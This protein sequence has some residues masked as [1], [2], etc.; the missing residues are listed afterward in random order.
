MKRGE[1]GTAVRVGRKMRSINRDEIEIGRHG[2][3]RLVECADYSRDGWRSL[4]LYLDRKAKKNVWRLGVNDKHMGRSYDAGLLHAYYPGIR[5]WV[6]AVA[7]GEDAA[8]PENDFEDRGGIFPVGEEARRF[9]VETVAEKQ[10]GDFPWSSNPQ[11]A[12]RGRYIVPAIQI[13]LG[14]SKHKAKLYLDALL[15]D[16]T[17]E[18]VMVN[19]KT[20]KK[21]LRVGNYMEIDNG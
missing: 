21:G 20:R 2:D 15:R 1:K 13:G 5:E 12:K 6:V 18:C 7:A 3:W 8:F 11:T 10:G 16:G 14:T 4:K 19:K 17:I 9:I